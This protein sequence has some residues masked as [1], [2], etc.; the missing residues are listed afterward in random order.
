M[1]ALEFSLDHG[2]QTLRIEQGVLDHFQ[3]YRQLSNSDSE[4][5]GLL[6]AKISGTVISVEK[7]TGPSFFDQRSRFSFFPNSL[8]AQC[9]I[10]KSFQEG[11]HY[12]GE[13]HTHPE[14][15]PRPSPRDIR[16]FRS[17]FQKSSHNLAG[18]L[19]V[20]SGIEGLFVA[21]QDKNGLHQLTLSNALECG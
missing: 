2:H 17:V 11:L 18:F 12:V 8:Y 14:N 4:A 16:S 19:F 15:F 9:A 20:I 5:G 21:I 13:W 7:A 3:R 1:S 6:F 10:K